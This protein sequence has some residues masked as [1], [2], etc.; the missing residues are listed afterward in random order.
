MNLVVLHFGETALAATRQVL[1]HLA[2]DDLRRQVLWGSTQSP[3]PALHPFG[4]PEI[5]DLQKKETT[6]EAVKR[7]TT[8]T[9]FP[10]MTENLTEPCLDVTLLVDEQVLRLQISVD[11]VQ[12]VKVFK[13][14]YN[15]GCVEAGVWFTVEK[16]EIN[17]ELKVGRG[18]D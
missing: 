6:L 2:E 8:T 9:T 17:K 5:C 15:L 16:E 1:T 12:R 10:V 13:C 18:E 7:K 4:E 3:G 14:Q 11:E